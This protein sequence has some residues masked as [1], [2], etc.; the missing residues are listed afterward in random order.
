MEVTVNLFCAVDTS[1]SF[2]FTF[3]FTS[4]IPPKYPPVLP[5]PMTAI[6]MLGD[7]RFYRQLNHGRIIRSNV[8]LR[9]GCG[10]T[11]EDGTPAV[12]L[13]LVLDACK[14]CPYSFEGINP[15]IKFRSGK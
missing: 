4:N 3:S 14:I 8:T 13:G 5:D 12:S 9:L 11:P 7:L 10:A 15:D 2:T 6:R 1:L